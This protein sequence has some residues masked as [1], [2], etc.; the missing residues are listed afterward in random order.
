MPVS[1]R[2]VLAWRKRFLT[3]AGMPG[4]SE[5]SSIKDVTGLLEAVDSVFRNA[6]R[7]FPQPMTR[8]ALD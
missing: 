8:D 5:I 3:S 2:R 1:D 4:G 6:K 7:A